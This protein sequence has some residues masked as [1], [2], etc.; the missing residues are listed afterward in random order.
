MN[1]M[2]RLNTKSVSVIACAVWLLA[3]AAGHSVLT[4]YSLTSGTEA[5]PKDS[6]PSASTVIRPT[7][8]NFLLMFV[9]PNCPCSTA[10]VA[11]LDRLMAAC[12][13]RLSVKIL[14]V[15]PAG[16]SPDWEKT[17]L[18]RSASSIPNVEVACDDGG[19]E[20]ALFD[21]STSGQ[22]FLYSPD[23]KLIFRG[24]ITAARGMSGD[25]AGSDSIASWVNGAKT[26]VDH[27]PVFGCPLLDGSVQRKAICRR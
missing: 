8:R 23:G 19:A 4:K 26:G 6:W 10:S 17:N 27:T 24:G 14:F 2:R 22:T 18:W 11:E 12:P 13:A 21:A 5:L 15:K 1:A 9:H 16:T 20:A 7:G 25:N 3:L